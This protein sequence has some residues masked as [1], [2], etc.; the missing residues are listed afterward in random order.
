MKNN[1]RKEQF[2]IAADNFVLKTQ[3]DENV[4]GIVLT[5]SYIHGTLSANSDLDIMVILDKNCNYRERGNTWIDGIEVEYFMNPPQQIRSY[6]QKEKNSPHTAHMLAHGQI[7]YEKTEEIQH[8]VSEAKTLIN[9]APS[10]PTPFQIELGKYHLDDL[11][12]D[13]LDCVDNSMPTEQ[14]LL[15]NELIE[16]CINLFCLVNKLWRAKQ[17]DIV[18]Q[19]DSIDPKFLSLVQTVLSNKSEIGAL[20]RYTEHLLGGKRS[21]E[22]IL[23]SDLDL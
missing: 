17:K 18:Q 2:K 11:Y 5:G 19:L 22:W 7:V 8:L 16:K 15:G 9:K 4:I 20:V 13:Y 12:K 10:A 1:N 14:T 3:Q 6:F 23:K 21:K